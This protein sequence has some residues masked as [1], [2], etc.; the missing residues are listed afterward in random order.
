MTYE[1]CPTWIHEDENSGA[2]AFG[3]IM[4]LLPDDWPE[5]VFTRDQIGPALSPRALLSK[6]IDGVFHRGYYKAEADCM[7]NFCK[8]LQR[9]PHKDNRIV[10]EFLEYAQNNGL[11]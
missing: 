5:A 3:V 2:I 4:G 1:R 10:I 6:M 11:I 7:A 9:K 8:S